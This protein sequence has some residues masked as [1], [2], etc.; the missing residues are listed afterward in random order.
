[1]PTWML[2]K[3]FQWKLRKQDRIKD[4]FVE[5]FL[6]ALNLQ[7]IVS[8]LEKPVLPAIRLEHAW[9]RMKGH[10]MRGSA[11]ADKLQIPKYKFQKIKLKWEVKKLTYY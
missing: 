11:I 2:K 8:Y 7:E 6:R 5:R 3:P 10:V 4:A 1:M 9:Y